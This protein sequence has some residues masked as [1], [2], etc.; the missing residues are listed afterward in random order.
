[1][2]IFCKIIQKQIPAK[3]IYEDDHTLV[4]L[5]IAEDVDGHLL[6][7]PKKHVTSLFDCDTETLH[8][9]MN[10]VKKVSRHLI[11]CGYDGCNL[12]NANHESA[13]QSVSHFHIHII[14]RKQNDQIDAW[15][16]FSGSKTDLNTMHQLLKMED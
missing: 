3:I 11:S 6:A 1:M 12:L 13:G 5:D 15:P 16:H 4:F 8:H 2:C 9:L 7:T 10:T 14:P